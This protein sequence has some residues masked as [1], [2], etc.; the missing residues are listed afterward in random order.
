MLI[1][2][3]VPHRTP[4]TQQISRAVPPMS[5]CNLTLSSGSMLGGREDA[6]TA[7]FSAAAPPAAGSGEP[8]ASVTL[9]VQKATPQA[10]AVKCKQRQ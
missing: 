5:W 1:I 8:A 10:K 6:P 4:K 2:S 9:M 3:L 7:V